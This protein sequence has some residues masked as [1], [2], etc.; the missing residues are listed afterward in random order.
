MTSAYPMVS[1]LIPAKNEGAVLARCLESLKKVDY[2]KDRIE[3][4]LADGL[5]TDN[6][7]D[8]ALRYGAKV[9]ANDGGTA[10]SGRNRAYEVAA[11][12]IIA[13]TDADCVVDAG[14]IKNALKYFGGDKVGGVG[15]VSLSPEESSGFGKAVNFIF[16]AAETA[17][18]TSHVQNL[19]LAKEADDIPTCNAFYRKEA[20]DKVM[21][22]DEN[23][24][25]AEDVWMNFCLKN[26]GYRLVVA[27]D[28]VV[29]HHRRRSPMLFSKQI[30]RFAIGRMQVARKSPRLINAFHVLAG[31]GLP[32]LLLSAVCLYLL[33]MLPL[34][35]AS[36]TG[37]LV[38][39]G[40]SALI[41][42]RSL[43][44]AINTPLA[45]ILFL[46]AWSIGFMQEFLTP[47]KDVSGK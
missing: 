13:C 2:P 41:I 22:V 43:S 33:G 16:R 32:F 29:W 1:I 9:V 24:L 6:T 35:F 36:I 42:S 30:Y 44:V 37:F 46:T 4:I 28:V 39:A 38:I 40:L 26:Q 23:L 25:T 11:G 10:V 17:R 12:D 34:F 21:P 20:L 15:G 31:I 19:P 18:S 45:I 14:W 3:I 47:I 5:S 7:K 27:P 8:I